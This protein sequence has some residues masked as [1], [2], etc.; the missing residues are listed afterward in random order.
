M[1]NKINLDQSEKEINDKPPEF[2]VQL[3]NEART[4]LDKYLASVALSYKEIGMNGREITETI[5][6]VHEHII[7]L[8]S[9]YAGEGELVSTDLVRKA[10]QKL[11]DP[12]II[13]RTLIEEQAFLQDHQKSL[14]N[15]SLLIQTKDKK[16]VGIRVVNLVRL[17]VL[18]SWVMTSSIIFMIFRYEEALMVG[19]VS[20]LLIAVIIFTSK[21]SSIYS[22][23]SIMQSKIKFNLHI[24]IFPFI[25]LFSMIV[26]NSYNPFILD[27]VM[28]TL[29]LLLHTDKTNRQYYIDQYK[30]MRSYMRD[31]RESTQ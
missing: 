9:F 2:E 16:S 25:Y 24:V 17:F 4:L 1:S 19:Q 12:E 15:Q 30:S 18:L 27:P 11:G 22:K 28:I 14:E 13:K 3:T 8:G 31:L 26:L 5:Q 7:K 10:I 6:E 29:W 23:N 20:Y 21:S